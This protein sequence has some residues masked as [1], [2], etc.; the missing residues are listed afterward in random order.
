MRFLPVGSC[1]VAATS[2]FN[3]TAAVFASARLAT[4]RRFA[5]AT[6]RNLHAMDTADPDVN[7]TNVYRRLGFCEGTKT[8]EVT[9]DDIEK[10]HKCA[11][12]RLEKSSEA[13]QNDIEKAQQLLIERL[14]TKDAAAAAALRNLQEAY[15]TLSDPV[16]RGAYDTTGHLTPPQAS[17]S[18]GPAAPSAQRLLGLNVW[19]PLPYG[20]TVD[21]VTELKELLQVISVT[22]YLVVAVAFFFGFE[23]LD[24]HG[25]AIML[26]ALSCFL[27][28]MLMPRLLPMPHAMIGT[29]FFAVVGIMN[30]GALRIQYR[31]AAR[32]AS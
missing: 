4:S 30:V 24:V 31:A 6:G 21:P 1:T 32:S 22:V 5:A 29:L 2:S 14:L 16:K 19:A 27:W 23:F 13:I 12:E 17:G 10:A 11:T 18:G 26:T 9:Q 7:S 8:N 28:M 3:A 20:R 15:E 25:Q